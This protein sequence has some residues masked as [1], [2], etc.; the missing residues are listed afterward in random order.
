[1]ILSGAPSLHHFSLPWYIPPV[2]PFLIQ[3]DRS[4]K[5]SARNMLKGT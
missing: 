3:D 1:M 4:M 2:L 5:I